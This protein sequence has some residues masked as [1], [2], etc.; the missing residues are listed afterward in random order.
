[1]PAPRLRTARLVSVLLNALFLVPIYTAAGQAPDWQSFCSSE[2]GGTVYVTPVFATGLNVKARMSMRSIEREFL[3]YLIGRYG[4]VST[5][6]FPSNCARQPSA[7][8]AATALAGV[9]TQAQAAGKK[10]EVVQW[11]YV[12]DTALA[13]LSF[14]FSRQ[15]EGRNVELS[16]NQDH[17]YCFTN[18]I[19][20]P[21]YVSSAFAAGAGPNLSLWLNSF[22]RFLRS[23]Y[24]F[25]GNGADPRVMN[26]VDCNIGRLSDAERTIKARSDGARS[27]GRKVI[28]TGWKPGD[29]PVAAQGPAKD[30]DKEPAPAKPSPTPPSAE[31][32]RFATDEGPQALALCQNDRMIDGPFDCY[33]VQ[34]AIY[35]YRIAHAGSPPEPLQELFMGE[36]LD[37]SACLKTNFVAVWAANRAM[38]NG[39]SSEKSQCVG[40]KFEASITPRP[41]PHLSKELFE[42]AMKGCPR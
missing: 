1:M 39:Y 9:K 21:L 3:Q 17:G 28:D 25:S 22:D 2:S 30:E 13:S 40:K 8:A 38:S 14:D 11:K 31:V 35:N 41:W 19:G 10:L 20:G 36:K 6:P 37:C 42:A 4:Q 27:A 23:K 24:G 33:G 5:A 26:P 7:E 15:G 18:A 29:A 32:R 34:R 16:G 12:T